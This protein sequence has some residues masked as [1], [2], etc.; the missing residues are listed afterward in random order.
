MFRVYYSG[1]N[2]EGLAYEVF[3]ANKAPEMASAI[4]W[5]MIDISPA[6]GVDLSGEGL[7]GMT[8]ASRQL[9]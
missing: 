3:P 5:R 8:R 4:Y 1:K 7:K 2:T 6:T 9:Y